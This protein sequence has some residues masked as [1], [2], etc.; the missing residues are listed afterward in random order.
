MP[1]N[2]PI[3][4][5]AG[6]RA[7]VLRL[8]AFIVFAQK[9]GL[10]LEEIRARAREAAAQPRARTRRLGEAVG[11]LDETDRGA[12]RRARA[13]EDRPRRV[14]R[15]RLPLARPL[16]AGQSR[17]SRRAPRRG[18]A[19][20]DRIVEPVMPF[21]NRV[22]RQ[23]NEKRRPSDVSESIPASLSIRAMIA[24]VSRPASRYVRAPRP[25]GMA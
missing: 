19:L 9:V 21:R 3:P 12:D 18:P 15:V 22:T 2:G 16:P 5:I 17:R 4:G 24:S 1:R 14:H 23:S 7:R 6:I 8:V 25:L 10:S 11:R 13:D 20:L